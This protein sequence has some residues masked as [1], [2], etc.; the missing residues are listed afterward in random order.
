MIPWLQCLHFNLVMNDQIYELKFAFA[1]KLKLF[2]K[3]KLEFELKLWWKNWVRNKFWNYFLNGN[4]TD[5]NPITLLLIYTQI[6]LFSNANSFP[7]S[8]GHFKSRFKSFIN[9][10]DFAQCL[11]W[12]WLYIISHFSN[13]CTACMCLLMGSCEC[14]IMYLWIQVNFSS[15]AIF[16]CTCTCIFY[17]ILWWTQIQIQIQIICVV[18]RRLK[19]RENEKCYLKQT[20][21]KAI[22]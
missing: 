4:N 21:Q 20:K 13:A 14:C 6:F 22:K 16:V 8:D 1:L 15:A 2:L 5:Y 9:S 17:C 11:L 10:F 19:I 18:A 7:P 3:L 12:K